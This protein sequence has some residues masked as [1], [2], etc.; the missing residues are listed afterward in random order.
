ML[1]RRLILLVLSTSSASVFA[2]A[3]PQTLPFT[4]SWTNVGLI[5]VN[6]D[7]SGVPGIEGYLGQNPASSAAPV[8]PRTILGTST[9][10]NDLSVIANA[11]DPAAL[12]S[13][14]VA[15]FELADP[16][17]AIQG[18]GTADWPY[19]LVRLNLSA[20]STVRVRYSLRDL[21]ADPA[22]QPVALQYRVGAT[23]NFVN[24]PAAFVAN[25]N[26]SGTGTVTAV[27]ATLP[28]DVDGQALVQVRMITGNGVG[29]DAFIGIDD[30][31]I[32]GAGGGVDIPPTVASVVPALNATGVALDA[33]ITVN[34]SEPVSLGSNWY[35][36]NCAISGAVAG[37]SS[38]NS[39]SSYTIN[40]TP[41][42]ASNELCTLTVLANQVTDTDGTPEQM[43][44][45]YVSAFTTAVDVAPTIVSTSPANNAGNVAVSANV[46]V[47]F[48]EP[49][50]VTD[51]IDLNCGAPAV[52]VPGATSGSGSATIVFNPTSNLANSTNCVASIKRSGIVDLDGVADAPSADAS[53]AFT[54]AAGAATYYAAINPINAQ[55]LRPALH[56]LIKG[57]TCF[58]YSGAPSAW[59]ILETADVAPGNSNLILDVYKNSRYTPISSRSGQPGC[60]AATCYNREHTWPNSLGFNDRLTAA[61]VGGGTPVP[62][63][64]YTDTHMLYLSNEDYNS[65]R[66][67]KPFDNCPG[68]TE[69][70][71]QVNDGQGGGAGVYPGNSNWTNGS[72]FETWSKRRGNLARAILYMDIRYEGGNVGPVGA[73]IA[74]PD[75]IVTDNLALLQTTPSGAFAATGFMGKL[76]TL[77]EWHRQDPPD[78]QECLR[79]AIVQASQGNRNP[80]IDNP[81]WAGVLYQD[82]VFGGNFEAKCTL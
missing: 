30:I 27:D 52:L 44:L 8:D 4:Q 68:C 14:G 9:A 11:T 62:N 18:S 31:Q 10:A 48:S 34:F 72:V 53:I 82:V 73:V 28:S 59:T 16:V 42:F 6:N 65:Q 38:S 19:L 1:L 26:A 15:E 70:V 75:L 78:E 32:T 23:G 55:I 33:N 50:A 63:C 39:A 45:D 74:E 7:W 21:D 61:P 49:V 71:T 40:P 2:D 66:G 47:V 13:G 43:A 37:V 5:T 67:N 25:A 58:T 76:S 35:T 69:L 20:E 57:H 60:T 3:V 12:G 64:P 56:D 17:V 29:V 24:V 77:L 41:V 81:E 54:T 51:W 80:F 79:N 36:L 22:I 46:I